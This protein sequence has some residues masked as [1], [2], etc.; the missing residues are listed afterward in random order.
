[1]I[2]YDDLNEINALEEEAEYE[3]MFSEPEEEITKKNGNYLL[4][5]QVG[6]CLII[7]IGITILKYTDSVKYN[8]FTAWYSDEMSAEIE[9]P[10]FVSENSVDASSETD[11][12]IS[13]SPENTLSSAS[14]EENTGITNI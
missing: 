6:F 4:L 3:E 2:K 13:S 5:I 1:M 7:L 11:N 8:S 10:T 9:L 12:I 14:L